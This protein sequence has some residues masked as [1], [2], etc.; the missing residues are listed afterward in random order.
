MVY[1]NS[2]PS[3]V[4]SI[5]VTDPVPG[6]LTSPVFTPSVGSYLPGT[7]TWTGLS[8]A[9]GQVATLT[10][11][12]TFSATASGTLTDPHSFPTRRSSDLPTPGNNTATDSDPLTPQADLSI[13]KSN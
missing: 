11:V 7:G 4:T 13:T 8:L 2:G 9:P 12:G 6:I 10:L 5:T 3:T 1:T